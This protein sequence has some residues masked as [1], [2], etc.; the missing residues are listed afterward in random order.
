MLQYNVGGYPTCEVKGRRADGETRTKAMFSNREKLR[1][2][3]AIAGGAMAGRWRWR[4]IV[5]V[6]DRR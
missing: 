6:E 1:M 4:A 3:N 2:P 5:D